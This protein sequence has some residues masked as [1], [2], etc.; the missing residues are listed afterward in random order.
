MR[1]LYLETDISGIGLGVMLLQTRDSM[2]FPQDKLPD[3]SI[4]RPKAFWSRNLTIVERRNSNIERDAVGILHRLNFHHYCSAKELGI[5][6][7]HKPL[8]AASKSM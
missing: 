3:N 4:P 5:I 6:T 7:D 2:S 8:V 1:S